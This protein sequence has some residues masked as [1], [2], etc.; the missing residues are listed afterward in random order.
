MLRFFG[1]EL[2]GPDVVAMCGAD[3]GLALGVF[4]GGGGDGVGAVVACGL[5]RS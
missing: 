3:E 4:G 1:V 2:G 5:C